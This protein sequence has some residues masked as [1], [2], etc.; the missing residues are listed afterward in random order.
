MKSKEQTVI[1]WGGETDGNGK[2]DTQA[3]MST[4]SG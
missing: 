1:N 4:V 3:H 2:K